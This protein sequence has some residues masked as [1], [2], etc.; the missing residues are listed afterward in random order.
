MSSPTTNGGRM[1]K[2]GY[3][4]DIEC[5]RTTYR[6]RGGHSIL[7]S[8]GVKPSYPEHDP[9][10]IKHPSNSMNRCFGWT[11]WCECGRGDDP[12]PTWP[13]WVT[14]EMFDLA[15]RLADEI[16][17]ERGN[18]HQ[19]EINKARDERRRAEREGVAS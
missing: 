7:A 10:C 3:T 15:Y 17:T 13:E 12:T 1:L 14:G 8:M 16:Q 18:H 9:S 6:L 19:R 11:Y 4:F 2:R 5:H